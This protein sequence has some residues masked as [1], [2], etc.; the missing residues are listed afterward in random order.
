MYSHSITFLIVVCNQKANW[1]SSSGEVVGEKRQEQHQALCFITQKNRYFIH[2]CWGERF[3]SIVNLLINQYLLNTPLGCLQD[4][5]FN[6]FSPWL[7]EGNWTRISHLMKE[8]DLSSAL[9]ESLWGFSPSISPFG[10]ILHHIKSFNPVTK[11]GKCVGSYTVN[12]ESV[13]LSWALSVNDS[14]PGLAGYEGGSQRLVLHLLS[15][16]WKKYLKKQV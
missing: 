12:T 13:H 6:L 9:E 4:P 7:R 10:S 5:V 3:Y 15:F 11:W 1:W 16:L 14:E 2:L 8:Y